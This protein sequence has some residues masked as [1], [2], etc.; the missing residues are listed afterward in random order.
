MQLRALRFVILPVRLL[1]LMANVDYMFVSHKLLSHPPSKKHGTH[2][3]TLNISLDSV[4]KQ[5][6]RKT[7]MP[8]Q[9]S[10]SRVCSKAH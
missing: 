2:T 10:G 3:H 9:P 6:K 5:C 4:T 7:K 1:A 8:V